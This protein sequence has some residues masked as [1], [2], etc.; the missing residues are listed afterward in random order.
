MDVFPF[1]VGN[2]FLVFPLVVTDFFEVFLLVS[3]DDLISSSSIDDGSFSLSLFLFLFCLFEGAITEKNKMVEHKLTVRKSS[4][5]SN[6][7]M[8]KSIEHF[9]G[10]VLLYIKVW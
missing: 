3:V 1:V 8:V 4:T 2:F 9:T 7:E 6:Y 10:N 5:T